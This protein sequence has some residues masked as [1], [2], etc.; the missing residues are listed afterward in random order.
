[1]C[2]CVCVCMYGG[3]GMCIRTIPFLIPT[4]GQ[5]YREITPRIAHFPL[6]TRNTSM[7]CFAINILDDEESEGSQPESFL[8]SLSVF[9]V[10]VVV[11]QAS[12]TVYIMDDDDDGK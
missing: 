4:A 2:V 9:D 11:N 12:A 1:M 3:G 6:S 7:L 10:A 5:D 8:L